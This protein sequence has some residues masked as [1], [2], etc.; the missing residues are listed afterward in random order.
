MSFGKTTGKSMT[1]SRRSESVREAEPSAENH[2]RKQTL[3]E[4]AKQ[5]LNQKRLDH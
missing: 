2:E 5:S 3:S 4:E 1:D